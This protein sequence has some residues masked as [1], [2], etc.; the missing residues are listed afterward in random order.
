MKTNKSK[1]TLSKEELAKIKHE[2]CEE[3]A[4]N[5]HKLICFLP[6][7]GNMSTR[8]DLMPVRDVR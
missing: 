3:L 2:I 4:L 1:S 6:F 5:R 7:T 8:F